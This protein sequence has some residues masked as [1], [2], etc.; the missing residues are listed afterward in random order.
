MCYFAKGLRQEQTQKSVNLFKNNYN[1]PIRHFI[2]LCVL[3]EN[4]AILFKSDYC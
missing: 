1:V 3:F 2:N 4:F